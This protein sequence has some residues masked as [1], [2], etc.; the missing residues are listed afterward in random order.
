MKKR[1]PALLVIIALLALLVWAFRPAPIDV[2]TVRVQT[3]RFERSVE[4][5]GWTRVRDRFIV[6]A[7]LAG[8]LARIQ[9]REGDAVQR[10]EVIAVIRPAAPALL[11]ERTLLEQRERV[12]TL[13]AQA[14]AAQVAISRAR[15]ALAQAQTDVGRQ[16]KLH[17]RQ[18]ISGAQVDAA[19]LALQLREKE[20]LSAE[21]AAQAAQHALDEARVALRDTARPATRARTWPVRSPVDGRV[22]RLP[23]QSESVVQTGAPLV[24]IGDPSQ[25]EVLVDLLTEDAA[26]V[27]PGMTAWLRNWGGAQALEARVRRVEPSAFTK[28]SALGVEEQR[29]NVVLDI[30]SPPDQWPA[31]GDRFRV[32]VRI[33]V[34]VAEAATLVPVGAVFPSGGRSGLFVVRDDRARLQEVDVIARNGQ[35]AWLRDALT[36]GTELVAY[37]PATLKDGTRIRRMSRKE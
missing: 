22:L 8:H 3:G 13:Q 24:E 26:Q 4:D 27:R 12:A 31:L 25:L 6:S 33:P 30:V 9:L 15:V 23:Q 32:D 17:E 11:D 7:P 29:V 10:N 37:P 28:V 1:L 19:R 2:E 34:Q 20:L 36:S 14:Q 35:Q 21:Q 5:D 16:E 18:F